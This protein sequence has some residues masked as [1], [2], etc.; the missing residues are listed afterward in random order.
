MMITPMLVTEVA[1][2]PEL[3]KTKLSD[4][5]IGELYNESNKLRKPDVDNKNEWTKKSSLK[6]KSTTWIKA[7]V[8]P[9]IDKLGDE[10]HIDDAWVNYLTSGMM[11]PLHNHPPHDMSFVIYLDVPEELRTE[12]IQFSSVHP[13]EPP[14]SIMFIHNNDRKH[15]CPQTGDM[16][17]FPSTLLHM[18]Y[19]FRSNIERVAIAGNIYYG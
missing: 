2:G 4:K 13:G 14:G 1:W 17:I 16:L 5:V 11:N 15:I 19:P 10:W 3:W 6:F 7:L 8:E 18:V 12:Q 9:Y